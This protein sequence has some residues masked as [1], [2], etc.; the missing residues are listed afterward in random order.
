MGV[1]ICAAG[2]EKKNVEAPP[3]DIEKL[4]KICSPPSRGVM[5]GIVF[6]DKEEASNVMRQFSRFRRGIRPT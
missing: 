4:L 1:W 2:A 6:V 3:V 5:T